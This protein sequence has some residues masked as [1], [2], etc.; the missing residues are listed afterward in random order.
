MNIKKYYLILIAIIGFVLQ[1]KAQIT[2]YFPKE[3]GSAITPFENKWFSEQLTALNEPVIFN[4]RLANNDETYRF[5]WLRSFHHPIAVR[6]EKRD[7]KYMLYWK[8]CDGAGGYKP[9]KLIL[10]KSKTLSKQQ[11][12]SFGELL[13]KVNFW[14]VATKNAIPGNDGA[15]WILE[16]MHGES[17]R[18]VNRWSPD[19]KDDYYKCC[20][21]L[22]DLTG[23]KI[24]AQDK[25]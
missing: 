16:G 21:Y 19:A 9:G 3:N 15:Q 18:V 1:T 25:Y 23:I 17:Y 5:T 2:D 24:S 8:M 22:L 10:N 13:K 20:D 12:D 6:V 14:N 7:Q 11:W 4:N